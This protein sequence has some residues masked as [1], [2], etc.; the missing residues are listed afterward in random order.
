MKVVTFIREQERFY[1]YMRTG[2]L[3]RLYRK[4]KVVTFIWEEASCYVIRE[5]ESYN[6][7]MGKGTFL[8]FY[9]KRKYVPFKKEEERCDVYMGIK[10]C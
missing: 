1:V 7:Y 4:R 5:E 10:S 9:W 8:R 2:K 6:V 3:L